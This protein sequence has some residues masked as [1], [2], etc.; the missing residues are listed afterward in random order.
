MGKVIWLYGLSSSGKTTLG[1]L[2][3]KSINGKVQRLD[4]DI[5]RKSLTA[6]LGFSVEDRFKNIKRICFVADLLSK[7]DICIIASFIT[8][9]RTYREHLRRIL[10]HRLILVYVDCSL[11]KCIKRDTKGLYRKAIN[12]QILNMTGISQKFEKEGYDMKIDTENLT[13]E[14]SLKM[15]LKKLEE[16]T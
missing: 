6:D 4:G 12:G 5:V 13:R 3:A 7:N 10:G 9:F 2:L 8:P 1:D 15:L 11:E 16:Y 14:E